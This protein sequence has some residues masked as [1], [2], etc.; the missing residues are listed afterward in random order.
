M[1]ESCKH[2]RT[3]LSKPL[4]PNLP[5]SPAVSFGPF[6]F[7]S[8]IVGR[9]QATGEISK[10]DIE[11]QTRQAMENIRHEL[12]RAGS[13]LENVLKITVFLTD[14]NRFPQMNDAYR[15]FFSGDTP[16]R[17]CV[18]VSALPDPEALV[19]IEAVAGQ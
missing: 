5:F 13:S 18:A 3:I 14:I 11:E 1:N 8:G 9:N 7:L 16:A 15:A 4:S 6:I 10:G 17:T 19:E 12:A 2:H